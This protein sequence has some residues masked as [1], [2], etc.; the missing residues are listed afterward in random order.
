MLVQAL[1]GVLNSRSLD[2]LLVVFS[3]FAVASSFLGVTLGLFDYL[4]DLFWFRRLGCGPLEN[5]IADLCPASCGGAVVPERIPV[6]HWL[7]WFSGYHL[8]GNCSGAVS[9]CIA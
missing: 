3:N 2:L 6:R 9:P 7:C 8:G 4:A 5:G 1:S